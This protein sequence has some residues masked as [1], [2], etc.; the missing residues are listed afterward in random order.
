VRLGRAIRLSLDG[1][2]LGVFLPKL[3]CNSANLRVDPGCEDYT[4]RTTLGDI[5]RAVSDIEPIS[6]ASTGWENGILVLP[7]GK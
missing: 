1:P 6:W 2:N 7:D 5:G 3:G 4:F